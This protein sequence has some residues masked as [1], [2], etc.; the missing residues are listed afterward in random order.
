MHNGR[1]LKN[2]EYV[3]A[4]SEGLKIN[5]MPLTLDPI[6]SFAFVLHL[7]LVSIDFI[8]SKIL[9]IVNSADVFFGLEENIMK[10]DTLLTQVR[11]K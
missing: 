3:S 9:I 1:V 6:A 11:L 5:T 7:D 2:P 8:N 10:K 4:R